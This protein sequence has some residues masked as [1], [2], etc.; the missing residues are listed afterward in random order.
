MVSAPE[1]VTERLLLVA[2]TPAHFDALIDGDPEGFR[3]ALG[4]APPDPFAPPPLTDDVIA[5]F[6]D[7]LLETPALQTWLFRWMIAR[8][9]RATLG[10]LGFAGPPDEHGV[11]TIGYLVYPAH[12]GKGYASEA[13]TRLIAWAL[14]QPGVRAV[15]ATIKPDNAASR[16]VAERAG[17]TRAG[18]VQSRDEG[19]LDLWE[20][21][22]D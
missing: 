4:A 15:Q 16:R 21:R 3:A 2:A 19:L 7:Q 11:V 6:R 8:R 14:A 5:W 1:I 13:V 20:R 12:E 18:A 17:F 22:A 9:D 10:S